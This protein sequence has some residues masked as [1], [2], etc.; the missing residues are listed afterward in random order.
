MERSAGN[1]MVD[2]VL[3]HREVRDNID[4]KKVITCARCVQILLTATK[5][6]KIAY[7]ERLIS[8]GNLEEARAVESFISPEE[9][10]LNEPTRKSR[11]TLVR[12]RFVREIRPA[13]GKSPFRSNRL[14][15]KGRSETR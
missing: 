3:C 14:L 5:E 11:P 10:V 2:C 9:E 7:R 1:N 8:A 15:D 12:K 6:N 4:P 13:Y